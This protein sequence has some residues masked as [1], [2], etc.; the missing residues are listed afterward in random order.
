MV[1]LNLCVR[2][3]IP[4]ITALLLCGASATQ[5]AD[6]PPF[7]RTVWVTLPIYH[8]GFDYIT[9]GMV[10]YPLNRTLRYFFP[11]DMDITFLYLIGDSGDKVIV[12]IED[13]GDD[14]DRLGL[15][16][17]AFAEGELLDT[18]WGTLY[19]SSSGDSFSLTTPAVHPTMTIVLISWYFT[20]SLGTLPYDYT[21]T[22]TYRP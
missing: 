20:P 11:L 3:L 13:N 2:M 14:G 10:K 5:A 15:L 4:L 1:V 18:Q 12:E 16:M 19:S 7:K 6:A 21:M 17:Y 9:E 22:V 8:L